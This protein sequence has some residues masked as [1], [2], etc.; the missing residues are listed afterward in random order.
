MSHFKD[1]SLE[2]L[3]QAR[4]SK[5]QPIRQIAVRDG[6]AAFYASQSAKLGVLADMWADLIVGY[7]DKA[8]EFWNAFLAHFKERG[9]SGVGPYPDRLPATGM[10]PPYREMQ[11]V[12]RGLVTIPIYVA[13]QG[14]DLYVSWR[15]F[16]QGYPD[17]ARIVLWVASAILLALPLSLERTLIGWGETSTKIQLGDLLSNVFLILLFTGI[18]G[19]IYGYLFREGDWLG[20]VREPVNEL[21]V[22]DVAS[23]SNAVHVSLL[24][25]ADTVGIDTT[26]LQEREPFYAARARK[27][28][29]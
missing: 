20:L 4:V 6:N 8:E 21:Q 11:F 7:G 15:V 14:K 12:K 17:L 3:R 26:K 27:R 19:A 1:E 18:F 10:W 13:V 22:D 28:R 5:N 2:A 29:I 25:A 9:M 16:A 24:A 23:L